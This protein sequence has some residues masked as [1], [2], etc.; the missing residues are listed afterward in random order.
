MILVKVFQD[1]LKENGKI[2][3]GPLYDA[4][5]VNSMKDIR[6]RLEELFTGI[7]QAWGDELNGCF[8]NSAG[9]PGKYLASYPEPID[10]NK[11]P[12]V[13]IGRL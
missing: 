7:W 1:L 6:P 9:L 12:S 2:E 3:R 11:K 8:E 13:T 4:F 5:T 10:N